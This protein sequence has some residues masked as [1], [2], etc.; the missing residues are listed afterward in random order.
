MKIHKRFATSP[1]IGLLVAIAFAP[2]A[3]A[4]PC[5]ATL[6]GVSYASLNL[7]HAALSSATI[8]VQTITV[9]GDCNE[10]LLITNDKGRLII[11]GG[12]ASTTTITGNPGAPTIQVRG[13][14]VTLKNMKITGGSHGI[15]VE[16]SAN[17]IIDSNE[18]RESGGN[19]ILVSQ[20]AF[21]VIIGNI[22]VQNAQHGILVTESSSARIGANFLDVSAPTYSRNS[23][24]TN[25][26]DGIRVSRSSQARIHGNIIA[27]HATGDGIAV[28]RMAYA[29]AGGNSI[30]FNA[31]G[32]Y[33]DLNSVVILGE[34]SP[35]F[36]N[37]GMQPNDGSSNRQSGIK[38]QSGAA[39]SGHLGAVR[40]LN[41]ATSQFSGGATPNTFDSSCP[42]P[43]SALLTP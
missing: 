34:D 12:S 14:G 11:D 2:S 35:V 30:D 38:C 13:K 17:A 20:G 3:Q 6:N 26:L 39:I 25:G 1:A 24:S 18:V 43:A 42:I 40:Q 16:R 27:S 9:S 36:G 31:N 4:A 15:H 8:S 28:T 22:I 7:A 29:E 5:A 23:I 37:Y 10:N 41:G 21:A 19:G 33:A 32:I